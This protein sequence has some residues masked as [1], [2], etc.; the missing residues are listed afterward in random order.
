MNLIIGGAYQGKLEFAINKYQKDI[1]ADGNSCILEDT[2][3]CEILNNFQ[4]LVKR[5]FDTLDET[6]QYLD[7]LLDKN[8]SV[9]IVSTEVGCGIVPI[10]KS[11][12]DYRELIGRVSCEISKRA[13]TVE[14]VFCGLGVTLK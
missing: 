8:P 1:I 9:I 2:Y 14:R 5:Y 13:D 12:R 10:E 7:T 6:I 3:S 4:N 11:D